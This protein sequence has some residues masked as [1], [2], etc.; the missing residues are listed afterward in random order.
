MVPV[1]GEEEGGFMKKKFEYTEGPI[2]RADP[3][4]LVRVPNFLPPPEE[5]ARRMDKIKI[6]IT[7]TADSIEF[8]KKRAEKHDIQY[9]RL[10][11]SILDEYVAHHIQLEKSE[12]KAKSSE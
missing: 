2:D 6:T 8:F 10:I 11:R 4:K 12:G 9:Q 7:L 3:K 1:T 5:L